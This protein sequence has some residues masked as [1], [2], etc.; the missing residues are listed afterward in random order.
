MLRW[1]SL[2]RDDAAV[3]APLF[4]ATHQII[5]ITQN[6]EEPDLG[7]HLEGP[8]TPARLSARALRRVTPRRYPGRHAGTVILTHIGL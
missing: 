6:A 2:I 7:F 5:P 1:R 3:R 8:V 4:D